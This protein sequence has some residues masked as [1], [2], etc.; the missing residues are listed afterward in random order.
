MR[1][2]LLL[3]K[4]LESP[5][6][7]QKIK[8]LQI[9]VPWGLDYRKMNGWDHYHPSEV[10]DVK[11]D[12]QR[13]EVKKHLKTLCEPFL[14]RMQAQAQDPD[15]SAV[16]STG[17]KGD[18]G[19]MHGRRDDDYHHW[20]G[21]SDRYNDNGRPQWERA[22]SRLDLTAVVSIIVWVCP[23]MESIMVSRDLLFNN[24]LFMNMLYA[25][26]TGS[27]PR[28]EPWRLSNIRSVITPFADFWD[29]ISND[30]GPLAPPTQPQDFLGFF[31]LPKLETL[32]LGVPYQ[33]VVHG[34]GSV[35]REILVSR[36]ALRCPP[37]PNL[38]TKLRLASSSTT[39]STKDDILQ[40]LL[41]WI[42]HLRHLNL[43]YHV[44]N[45][46]LDAR[47]LSKALKSVAG[48]LE[49]L[50]VRLTIHQE[51][52]FQTP[53]EVVCRGLGSLRFL[54]ALKS[55]NVPLPLLQEYLHIDDIAPHWAT[56]APF[57]LRHN[58]NR[59]TPLADVLP[60]NLESFIVNSDL[61]KRS[62]T[63]YRGWLPDGPDGASRWGNGDWSCRWGNAARLMQF[64]GGLR[65]AGARLIAEGG[66]T[67][68]RQFDQ[69][70]HTYDE[71]DEGW[72][73]EELKDVIWAEPLWEPEVREGGWIEPPWRAATPK[74][75]RLH[76]MGPITRLPSFPAG[77]P[78][79]PIG[80]RL[81]QDL[82]KTCEE[83]G[84]EVEITGPSRG[85]R[86]WPVIEGSKD[87]PHFRH[88]EDDEELKDLEWDT[89]EEWDSDG[90]DEWNS[91]DLDEWDSDG[92]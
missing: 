54:T 62:R 18:F 71:D 30:V 87:W 52:I 36:F 1:L 79:A 42:I 56:D 19:W 25:E 51:F 29:P 58:E 47:K 37:T 48:T 40:T 39:F 86:E 14:Q 45:V 5:V 77:Q 60:P 38:L 53:E 27:K 33:Y 7:A 10:R 69:R 59:Y 35:R 43:R 50:E 92:L 16:M 89:D 24:T 26:L 31:Y 41:P 15:L 21:R 88:N 32:E 65:L 8:R 70:W 6:R 73:F 17:G 49:T 44:G 75:R 64:F 61:C 57:G 66:Q 82:K 78:Q 22:L 55:L 91:E 12:L 74:L 63:A 81:K 28:E 80:I 72:V 90:L 11:E 84:L 76:L 4:L 68:D 3:R 13:H 85:P 46:P 20:Y 23:N 9:T 83:Q 2:A 34:V 67:I